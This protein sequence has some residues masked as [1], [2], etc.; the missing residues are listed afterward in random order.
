VFKPDPTVLA[1]EGIAPDEPFTIVRMVN[2]QASH[3]IGD[4]GVR[5][6]RTVIDTLMNYGRVIISSE[7]DLPSDLQ[8][9]QMKGARRNMLH[10]QAFARLYFGESATMACECAMLGVP[11]IFLSTSRRGYINTLQNQHDMVYSFNDPLTGQKDALAKAV[12]LLENPDTPDIWQQKRQHLLA[13]LIDVTQFIVDT[14]R[15]YARH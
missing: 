4:S 3:D 10:L 12:E 5:D 9:L 14:V 13:Q 7:S 1:I 6:L 15:H 11:A 2:W 8:A